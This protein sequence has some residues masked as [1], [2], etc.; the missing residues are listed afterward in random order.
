[1]SVPGASAIEAQ[2]SD[3]PADWAER[4]SKLEGAI[5]LKSLGGDAWRITTDDAGRAT[6]AL[7]ALALENGVAIHVAETPYDTVGVDTEEDL[8]RV[9]ALLA[10]R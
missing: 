4:L 1:M 9:I 10:K 2:F 6:M 7:A 3:V 8:E 5:A